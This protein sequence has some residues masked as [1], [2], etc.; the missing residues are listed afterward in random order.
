VLKVTC[1]EDLIEFE[2]ELDARHPYAEVQARAGTPRRR[3]CCRARRPGRAGSTRRAIWTRAP[4]PRCSA[5][6]A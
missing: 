4:S 3:G 2:A 6:A 5:S 1:G